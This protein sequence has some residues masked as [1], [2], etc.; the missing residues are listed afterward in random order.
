MRGF[1]K[2]G[3]HKPPTFIIVSATPI[4]VGHKPI[5]IEVPCCPCQAANYTS[6]EW[7]HLPLPAPDLPQKTT[8]DRPTD[9]PLPLF[10][11]ERLQLICPGPGGIDS[12]K[13]FLQRGTSA[14][15]TMNTRQIRQVANLN[16]CTCNQDS[17]IDWPPTSFKNVISRFL[18]HLIFA[19]IGRKNETTVKYRKNMGRNLKKFLV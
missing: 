13:L 15:K 18:F 10:E 4:D 5:S 2:A 1:N 19:K 17:E 16:N 8:L 6:P 14:S 3:A 12:I 9:F 11:I 7:G